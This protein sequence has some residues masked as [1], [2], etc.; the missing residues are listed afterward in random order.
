M[1]IPSTLFSLAACLAA[2]HAGPA[3]ADDDPP[4][5]IASCVGGGRPITFGPDE[6]R[7][8]L[9]GDDRELFSAAALQRYP[10]L[11]RD[12]FEPL[13]IVLWH[14]GVD[15]LYISLAPSA[16]AREPCFTATFTG[17]AFE[18]TPHLVRKYFAGQGRT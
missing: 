1:R 11:E 5:G 13:Q 10:M 17:S 9:D 14:R 2:L 3:R 4:A 12:G 6:S 7:V 8:L 15:W 18:F 16:P